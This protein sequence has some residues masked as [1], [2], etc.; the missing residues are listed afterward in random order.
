MSYRKIKTIEINYTRSSVFLRVLTLSRKNLM[1]VVS[2]LSVFLLLLTNDGDNFD[3]MYRLHK[4]QTRA[5]IFF[6]AYD[7]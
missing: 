5:E 6:K 2:M 3:V 1:F 4:Q 7:D